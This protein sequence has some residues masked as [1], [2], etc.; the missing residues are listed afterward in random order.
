MRQPKTILVVGGQGAV[1]QAAVTQLSQRGYWVITL[2]GGNI[3]I[4]PIILYSISLIIK[5]LLIAAV[6]WI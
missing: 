6:R 4:I 5:P 3:L 2:G 1:G